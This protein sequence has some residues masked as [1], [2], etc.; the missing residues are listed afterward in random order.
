MPDTDNEIFRDN[1]TALLKNTLK[2]VDPPP[3]S[4]EQF[5]KAAR[6]ETPITSNPRRP[7]LLTPRKW[8]Y[9]LGGLMLLGLVAFLFLWL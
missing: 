8:F 9:A 2:P 4:D 7:D 3:E 6:S 1:V 5:L